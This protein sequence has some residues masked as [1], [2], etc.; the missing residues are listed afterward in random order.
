MFVF[1]DPTLV[2]AVTAA[3]RRGV[4]V[5]VMLNPVRRS[6]EQDN[7]VTRKAL[8]RVDIDVKDANPAFALTHEKSMVVDDATAFVKSLN[9]T[10]KDLTEARDYAIVTERRR[11]VAEITGLLRGRLEPRG[12]RPEQQ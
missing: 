10:T 2:K 11:E 12:I 8:E 4:K 5:R 1:S 7:E 6:G 3:K 9:W